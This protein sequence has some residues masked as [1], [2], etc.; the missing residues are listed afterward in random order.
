VRW[1]ASRIP[2]SGGPSDQGPSNAEDEDE[3]EDEEEEEEEEEEEGPAPANSAI[4]S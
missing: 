4:I 2:S 1:R 3:D